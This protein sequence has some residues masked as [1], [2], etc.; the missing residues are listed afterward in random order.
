SRR[1]VRESRAPRC[2]AWK[3]PRAVAPGNEEHR[4][5]AFSTSGPRVCVIGA[6]P[7]SGNLGVSGA[8]G[9]VLGAV[10]ARSPQARVTVLDHGQGERGAEFMRGGERWEFLRAGD[11]CGAEGW[12]SRLAAWRGRDPALRAVREAD[13]VLDA[14]GGDGVTDGIGEERF[15]RAAR[16]RMAAV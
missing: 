12:K 9:A 14:G 4:V 7:D 3:T 8:C 10:F 16:V 13:L 11:A 2:C 1:E 15:E 5:G 6:A